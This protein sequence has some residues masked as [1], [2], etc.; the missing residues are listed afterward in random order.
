MIGIKKVDRRPLAFTEKLYLFN[1]VKGMAITL[2][3]FLQ[4]VFGK[5]NIDTIAAGR[6]SKPMLP[7]RIWCG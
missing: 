3:H 4:N 1:V 5:P 7:R 2:R 6:G